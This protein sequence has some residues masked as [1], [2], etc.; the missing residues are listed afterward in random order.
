[1]LEPGH[2]LNARLIMGALKRAKYWDNESK[3]ETTTIFWGHIGI[4]ENKM[5]TEPPAVCRARSGN[6]SFAQV[7]LILGTPTY[8]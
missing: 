4:M 1:M 6:A 8:S 2:D 3:M 5:E 7:P